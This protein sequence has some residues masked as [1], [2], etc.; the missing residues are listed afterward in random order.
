VEGRFL[1][2]HE[3]T[4]IQVNSG[5]GWVQLLSSITWDVGG[6]LR[7]HTINSN[8]AVQVAYS[9]NGPAI[10]APNCTYNPT[11]TNDASGRL[12]TMLV[13]R[14]AT[15][16][17]M[18][19]YLW[20]AEM[21]SGQETC[22]L[23][24]TT[25]TVDSFGVDALGQVTAANHTNGSS[26]EGESFVYE[27]GSDK[28]REASNSNTQTFWENTYDAKRR[29]LFQEP[30]ANMSSTTASSWYRR[31]FYWDN[32]GRM[33][34]FRETVVPYYS[35]GQWGWLPGQAIDL[36]ANNGFGSVYSQMVVNGAACSVS[37]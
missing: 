32:D 2:P 9:R 18:R 27:F 30:R 37:G 17:M 8:P 25:P 29:L 28:K 19:R 4:G 24:A 21:L 12:T 5:Q 20:N 13:K 15:N 1:R 7:D 11:G 33:S 6:E 3:V 10:S 35:G 22:W 31:D 16:L 14:G 23:G 36:T 34:F 26:N